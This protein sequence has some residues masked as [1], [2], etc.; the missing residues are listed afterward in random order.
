VPEKLVQVAISMETLLDLNSLSIEEATGHLCTVGQRKKT[1]TPLVADTDVRLLLTEEWSTW[2]KMKEKSGSSGSSSSS[3]G[4]SS[5]RG[6]GR[7]RGHGG[8]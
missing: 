5:H 8:G 1:A 2:M 4:G 3:E 7:G 6:R